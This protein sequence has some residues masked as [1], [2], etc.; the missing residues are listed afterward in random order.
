MNPHEDIDPQL[1]DCEPTPDG[2]PPV[3]CAACGRA[4]FLVEHSY[5]DTWQPVRDLRSD[6]Q[7]D[8]YLS[9]EYGDDVVVVGYGCACGWL[10]A[11][12]LSMRER[13]RLQSHTERVLAGLARVE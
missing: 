10:N 6:G 4:D 5:R 9:F 12:D 3:M 1:S 13:A 11:A 7:A 2:K 8:D